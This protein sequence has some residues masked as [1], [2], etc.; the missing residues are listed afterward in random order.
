VI[1]GVPL[2]EIIWG[3][4]FGGA[5][6]MFAMYLFDARLRPALQSNP[7]GESPQP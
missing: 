6:P 7:G 5:W 4:A 1:L 3:A 2:D